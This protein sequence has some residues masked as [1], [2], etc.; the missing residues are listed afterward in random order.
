MSLCVCLSLSF[1]VL[2]A[3]RAVTLGVSFSLLRFCNFGVDGGA[4]KLNSEFLR[5]SNRFRFQCAKI[6]GT[7]RSFVMNASISQKLVLGGLVRVERGKKQT[8]GFPF[9]FSCHT[10]I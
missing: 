1:I 10:V 9:Y 7:S 8:S 2:S 4:C 3:P 6:V 5:S